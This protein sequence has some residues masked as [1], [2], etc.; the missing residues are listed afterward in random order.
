MPQGSIL[1]PLLFLIYVNDLPNASRILD[2]IMFADDTNL[3]YSHSNIKTLFKTANEELA[4]VNEWFACNKLSLNGDKTKYTF[5]HKLHKR[6]AIPLLLPEPQINNTVIKRE[7]FT[8]FL[9]VM[10]DE[11]LTWKKHI[12]LIENKIS[13]NVGILY[14]TKYIINQKCLKY[15]Y[16]SFIHSYLNYANITW[17]STNKTKLTKLLKLQKH[18]CR[19]IYNVDKMA[20]TKPLMILLNALNVYQLNIFQNILL[21]YKSKYNL[22]PVIFKKKI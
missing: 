19:I 21:T 6:E 15:I 20:H 7:Y 4:K 12:N 18:A 1:G 10:L 22:A 13:K 11:N 8:K 17:A 3:F 16:F 9:G 2:P 5:F 14:K